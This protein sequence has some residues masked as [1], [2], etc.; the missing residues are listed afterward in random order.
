MNLIYKVILLGILILVS[1]CQ[2][3]PEVQKDLGAIKDSLS[4]RLQVTHRNEVNL[5]PQAENAIKDWQDYFTMRQT[6]QALE[7]RSYTYV[8]SE[9]GE[10]VKTSLSMNENINDSIATP[11]IRSRLVVLLTKTSTLKQEVS[12]RKPDTTTVNIE[13]T[14]LYNAFQDLGQQLNIRF[15]KSVRDLL[16]EYRVE[17]EELNLSDSTSTN[18]IAPT[19]LDTLN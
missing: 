17:Q 2:D 1:G 12:K 8:Q 10:W 15:Q 19:Q 4:I 6:M 13:A 16:E 7:G 14:E 9:A 11:A 5:S 3:E 18:T